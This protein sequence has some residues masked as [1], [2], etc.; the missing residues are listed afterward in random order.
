MGRSR[1]TWRA[2]FVAGLLFAVGGGGR[3]RG[4][5]AAAGSVRLVVLIVIDQCRADLFERYGEAFSPEG[6]FRRLRRE[7][8][9]FERCRY[10]HLC[11]TTGPGHA[12]IATGACPA[13]HGIVG[14][15]WFDR[16]R[17]RS[18]YCVGDPPG[19]EMLCAETIADALDRQTG[20]RAR[21]VAVS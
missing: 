8:L 17:G 11:T 12:T 10:A 6:G 3:A 20:G 4:G 1:S 9:R 19:P 16:A 14:N 5:A 2:L 18:V 13:V 15:R 7:A 21:I